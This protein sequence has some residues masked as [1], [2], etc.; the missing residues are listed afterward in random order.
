MAQ[1]QHQTVELTGEFR[2]NHGYIDTVESVAE[3]VY[4]QSFNSTINENLLHSLTNEKIL[5]IGSGRY[6]LK[7]PSDEY[8][9]GDYNEYIIKI[10]THHPEYDGRT[11]NQY[12]ARV[13]NRLESELLFPV[14]NAC[15]SGR[16]LV[17]PFG[18][19]VTDY[20][21]VSMEKERMREQLSDI[22][23]AEDIWKCNML[24]LDGEVRLCDYGIPPK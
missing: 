19:E 2:F 24:T 17:M 21:H 1:A 16:W 18:E 15:N 8:T 13:W 5:G 11:Q 4:D 6:V 22:I 14:V 20:G 9:G 3:T 23:W 12:E 10:A 7:I